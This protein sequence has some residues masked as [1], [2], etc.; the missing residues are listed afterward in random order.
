MSDNCK[1]EI[2]K[3]SPKNTTKMNTY[4]DALDAFCNSES[5][6]NWQN[7][8]LI[9]VDVSYVIYSLLKEDFVVEIDGFKYDVKFFKNRKHEIGQYF[10]ASPSPG[11]TSSELINKGFKEGKWFLVSDEELSDEEKRKIEEDIELQKKKEELELME[12]LL[13]VLKNNPKWSTLYADKI[14]SLADSTNKEKL[15]VEELEKK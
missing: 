5:K 1:K 6:R 10:S 14:K 11:L 12:G 8:K 9:D 13:D 4:N 2:K 15:L 3:E 7:Y